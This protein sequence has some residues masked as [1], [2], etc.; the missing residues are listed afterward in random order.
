MATND[1][2]R[3][4]I[5]QM[6]EEGKISAEE[7]TTLLRA[8]GTERGARP[9]MAG[10]P[11]DR[12]YLRVQ[13]TDLTSGAA[14]VNVTVPMALV[15]AGLRIAQRFAPEFDGFDMEELEALLASG[16][17]GKIVEVL[18]EKDNERVEVYVE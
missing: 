18:D 6:L 3:M 16:A 13:V 12:R 8:L 10:A 5:L 17:D 11:G 7:A 9:R 1:N 14:K 4:K 15:S 2:E